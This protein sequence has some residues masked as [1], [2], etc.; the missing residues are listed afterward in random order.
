MWWPAFTTRGTPAPSPTIIGYEGSFSDVLGLF[1]VNFLGGGA[2]ALVNFNSDNLPIR[3][4]RATMPLACIVLDCSGNVVFDRKRAGTVRAAK[5]AVLGS[6]KVKIRENKRGKVSVK[7]TKAGKSFMRK[8][9]RAKVWAN[10]TLG[11]G[12]SKRV[13]SRQITLKR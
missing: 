5:S 8:H 6:G 10:V 7:L 3:N 12:K 4:G 2:T 9:K 13:V 11:R 1:R